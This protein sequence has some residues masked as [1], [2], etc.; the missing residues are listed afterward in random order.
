MPKNEFILAGKKFITSKKAAL[1]FGYTQ[2]Y[3]GQL[4][5]GEK[6]DAR[7]IGRTWYVCEQ[8]ILE[9]KKL[10]GVPE[11]KIQET[12]PQEIKKLPVAGE[13]EIQPLKSQMPK[14]GFGKIEESIIPIIKELPDASEFKYEKEMLPLFP[15]IGQL[16][17]GAN[18]GGRKM[19]SPFFQKSLSFV[20]AVL[21]VVGGY[22][23]RDE[24]FV[25]AARGFRAVQNGVVAAIQKIQKLDLAELRKVQQPKLS[26]IDSKISAEQVAEVFGST[27]F[28]DGDKLVQAV[29][30]AVKL[31]SFDYFENF[32]AAEFGAKTS[33]FFVQEKL[34]ALVEKVL[35]DKQRIALESVAETTYEKLNPFFQK[36]SRFLALLFGKKISSNLAIDE[37][38]TPSI[39]LLNQGGGG[40]VVKQDGV[41]STVVLSPRNVIQEITKNISYVGISREE[42]EGRLK[43]IANK[44]FS[45]TSRLS[46]ATA[47][48]NTYINNVYSTVAGSNNID[49]LHKVT[50]SDASIFTGGTV[51]ASTI[52][53]SPISGSTGSFTT[54]A[55]SGSTSLATTT[56]SQNLVVDT[57]TLYVDSTN[58]RVGIGTTSPSDTF[59]INGATYFSQISAPSITTDRLYN[60]GGDLY[61]A[62]NLIGSASIGNWTTASGN[63][64]RASGNVGIGTTS[65]YAKLSVNGGG[66]FWNNSATLTALD[67]YGFNSQ[68]APLFR[69]SSTTGSATS[70]A[71]IIDSNGKVGVGTSTPGTDFAVQGGL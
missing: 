56:I 30:G 4:C 66:N 59:A 33:K 49:M 37:I 41:S 26:W 27:G 47:N 24:I 11:H 36:T 40:E 21:L 44:F 7:R 63:V 42:F 55:A 38:T 19:S 10:Y 22:A 3:I 25:E 46:T 13:E 54:L 12:T 69:V 65:P 39:P 29:S 57:D 17:F 32:T 45:E 53:D 28:V 8:S 43:D 15:E 58:N 23:N 50:I 68:T 61:F 6:V 62:G 2:D 16:A 14:I 20:L 52:T 31:A 35:P 5:R 9:H 64:Y 71:F 60:T 51:T 67:V 34:L 48:N 1:L 70:T 18:F